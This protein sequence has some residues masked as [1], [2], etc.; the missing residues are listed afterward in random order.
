[1]Q[2][3]NTSHQRCCYI[4]FCHYYYQQY[5]YHPNISDYNIDGYPDHSS[6]GSI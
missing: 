1:M 5:G 3:E 2:W 6:G 4:T